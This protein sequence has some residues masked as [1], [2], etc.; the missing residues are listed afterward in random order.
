MLAMDSYSRDYV[1]GCRA[2]MLDRV[3]SFQ[4]VEAA[5]RSARSGSSELDAA[6]NE[7]ENAFFNDLLVVMDS[8]FVHRARA[9][10]EKDGNALNEVRLM[11]HSIMSNDGVMGVDRTI[12][13][14]PEASVLKYAVGDEIR[15]TEDDFIVVCDAFFDEID[16]KFT[17]DAG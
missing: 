3:A 13:L 16:R 7:L 10:E 12:K 6:L 8:S 14:N 1:D 5:A 11:T 15:L 17:S 4:A 9:V 2:R